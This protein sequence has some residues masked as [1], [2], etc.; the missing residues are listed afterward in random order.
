MAR[1]LRILIPDGWYDVMSRGNRRASL[2]WEDTDRRRFL[3]L[4]SELAE[5]FHLEVHALIRRS[6]PT[7]GGWCGAIGCPGASG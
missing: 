5:R 6:K 3:G 1:P 4:V 2:F 7:P